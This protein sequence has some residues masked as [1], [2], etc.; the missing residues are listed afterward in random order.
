MK[1]SPFLSSGS[2]ERLKEFR[3]KLEL[4]LSAKNLSSKIKPQ[5]PDCLK[6]S[7]F[8]VKHKSY[9][10]YI[11]RSLTPKKEN[12]PRYNNYK[13]SSVFKNKI[14]SP[15]LYS[16]ANT[17]LIKLS[18]HSTNFDFKNIQEKKPEKLSDLISLQ[19]LEEATKIVTKG[20]IKSI[21]K[22]YATRLRAFCDE[23][24]AKLRV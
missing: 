12:S 3:T 16:K 1:S 20:G 24:L 11:E 23:V 18:G 5:T 13:Y 2:R 7:N 6:K 10:D 4:N 8:N 19:S 15:K 17:N 22:I 14:I 21:D 9:I